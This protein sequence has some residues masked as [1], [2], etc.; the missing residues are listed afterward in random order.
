MRTPSQTNSLLSLLCDPKTFK[1]LNPPHHTWARWWAAG[2]GAENWAAGGNL[3]L[4]FPPSGWGEH[5]SLQEGE[6]YC[7]VDLL[8]N[9]KQALFKEVFFF[10]KKKFEPIFSTST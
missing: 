1:I 8:K 9:P 7:T 2:G 5:L 3:D 10:S 6:G 4:I